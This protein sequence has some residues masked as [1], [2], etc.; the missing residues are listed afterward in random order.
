MFVL[1]GPAWQVSV[2]VSD[3]G[4]LTADCKRFWD[5][6]GG[7]KMFEQPTALAP[8]ESL[9]NFEFQSLWVALGVSE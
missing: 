1:L 5:S 9:E 7:N 8:A 3:S 6:T 2:Q 4:L